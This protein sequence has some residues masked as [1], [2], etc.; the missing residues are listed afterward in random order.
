VKN[1]DTSLPPATD[2]SNK[3]IYY[4]CDICA[5]NIPAPKDHRSAIRCPTCGHTNHR[6]TEKDSTK[7]LIFT[8]TAVIFYIP[9][10]LLPFMSLEFYGNINKATIWTGIMD[11]AE[12]GS[13]LIALVVFLASILVP[14]MKLVI[15]LYLTLTSHNGKNPRFKTRLYGFIEAIGRWSMIDIFLLTILVAIMKIASWT[16][17]HAEPG[18]LMFLLV[19][20]FTMLAST[21][22]DPKLIWKNVDEEQN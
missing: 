5:H 15:M 8:L 21:Y 12:S 20:I 22:F 2:S 19:V 1:S 4:I 17:V 10:N 9:A 18:A 6:L 3:S 13:W 7:A 11:L 14:F 16:S